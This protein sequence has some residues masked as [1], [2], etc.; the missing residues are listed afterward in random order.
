MA[1]GRLSAPATVADVGASLSVQRALTDGGEGYA[2]ADAPRRFVFPEDHGAHPAFRTEWWYVT[3]HVASA[4]GRR[5]GFQ[6]TFFRNALTPR[7]AARTSRWA[8]DQLYLAHFAVTDAAGQRLH[9]FERFGRGALGLAGARTTPFR[10]WVEDWRLEANSGDAFPWRV[11][12]ASDGVAIDLALTPEKPPVLHGEAGWSRKSANGRN[13][14]YYYSLTRLRAAGT[15]RVPG[16]GR[17]AVAG[18]PV[19][20]TAWLDREWSTS[21]LEPGQVGWDW[22]GLQLD[23]GTD[24]MYFRL[25][26]RDGGQSFATGTIVDRAGRAR[27]L[28]ASAILAEPFAWWTSPRGAAYPVRWRVRV[29]SEGLDLEVRPLV[30][31]QELALSFRY[32]EGAVDVVAAGRAAGRGYLELTGYGDAPRGR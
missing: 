25:R 23:D 7:P 29:P 10:V 32:W 9:A 3:G 15:F 12:A 24:L 19:G 17:E 5:Y 30:E 21:A 11:R 27:S 8:A 28:D 6:L 31:N 14:S 22:F 4:D 2:R 1:L 18:T 16:A 13:A 20:G 26:A